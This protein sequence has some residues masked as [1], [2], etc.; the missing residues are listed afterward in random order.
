MILTMISKL[1]I[2]P[3]RVRNSLK[4]EMDNNDK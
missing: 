4:N 1:I 3:P 2:G